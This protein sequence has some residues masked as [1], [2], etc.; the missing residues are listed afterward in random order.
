MQGPGGETNALAAFP[1]P[2]ERCGLS[3][4]LAFQSQP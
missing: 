1:R 2:G 4:S 3:G